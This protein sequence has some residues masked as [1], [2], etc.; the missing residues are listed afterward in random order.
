MKG[1]W[2]SQGWGIW[3]EGMRKGWERRLGIGDENGDL[4]RWGL[5]KKWVGWDLGAGREEVDM[6]IICKGSYEKVT[7][8]R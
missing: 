3:G 1:F 5:L 4:G 7:M 2:V 8:L 6:G